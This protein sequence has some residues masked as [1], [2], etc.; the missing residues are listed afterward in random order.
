MRIVNNSDPIEHRDYDWIQMNMPR[1]DYMMV[2]CL[3]ATLSK[4]HKYHFNLNIGASGLV[5]Q[6]LN[7]Y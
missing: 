6:S 7:Y 4:N 3:K 1:D 5:N 2:K